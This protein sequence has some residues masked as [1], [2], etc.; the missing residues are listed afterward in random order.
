MSPDELQFP[1]AYYEGTAYFFEPSDRYSPTYFGG[2]SDYKLSG[3]GLRSASL[4]HVM[5]LGGAIVPALD[6]HFVFTVPLFYG[7]RHDGCRLTYAMPDNYVCQVETLQPAAA[8]SDFPYSDFPS[9]LPYLPLRLKCRR[10]CTPDQFS[11][12]THQGLGLESKAMAVVVPP[13]FVGGVSMWGPGGDAEGVQIVFECDFEKKTVR[14][15][16]QCS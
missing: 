12:W 7:L 3:K 14:A 16:N 9:L 5:T 15:T 8:E 13:L 4:H 10:Q 1:V 6:E 2:P 11:A